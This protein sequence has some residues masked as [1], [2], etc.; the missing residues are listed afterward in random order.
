MPEQ[1]S[2]KDI[3]R[4]SAGVTGYRIVRLSIELFLVER[5]S[6]LQ[7]AVSQAGLLYLLYSLAN[8]LTGVALFHFPNAI[9]AGAATKNGAFIVPVLSAGSMTG[10]LFGMF[11]AESFSTMII[12]SLFCGFGTAAWFIYYQTLTNLAFPKSQ[13]GTVAQMRQGYECLGFLLISISLAMLDSLSMSEASSSPASDVNSMKMSIVQQSAVVLGVLAAI[14]HLVSFPVMSSYASILVASGSAAEDEDLKD[15][16]EKQTPIRESIWGALQQFFGTSVRQYF[17]LRSIL[18]AFSAILLG[19]SSLTTEVIFGLQPNF[20]W[21]TAIGFPL[22]GIISVGS[23]ILFG[24]WVQRDPNSTVR[25]GTTGLLVTLVLVIIIHPLVSVELSVPSAK[26]FLFIFGLTVGIIYSGTY[27]AAVELWYLRLKDCDVSFVSRASALHELGCQAVIAGVFQLQTI[28]IEETVSKGD[29]SRL[30]EGLVFFGPMAA[31]LLIAYLVAISLPFPKDPI[32]GWPIKDPFGGRCNR[33]T[34]AALDKLGICPIA[35]SSFACFSDYRTSMFA[36]GHLSSPTTQVQRG[37]PVD[38]SATLS[39]ECLQRQLQKYDAEYSTTSQDTWHRSKANVANFT[40]G[41]KANLEE[42]LRLIGSAHSEIWITTWTFEDSKS[43]NLLSDA[44]IA[45]AQAGVDVRVIVD[46]CNLFYLYHKEKLTRATQETKVLHKLVNGGVQVKMLDTWF[47]DKQPSYVCGTHRKMMLVDGTFL[48]TGGLN[49][50]D[51]YLLTDTFHFKDV[52]VTLQ[53]SSFAE[54]TRQLYETLWSMSREVPFYACDIDITTN[55]EK[56]LS[57]ACSDDYTESL[58]ITPTETQPPESPNRRFSDSQTSD[59]QQR[60]PHDLEAPAFGSYVLTATNDQQMNSANDSTSPISL[61]SC[62]NREVALF[63]LDHKAGNPKGQDIIFS[64]LFFLIETAQES[65]ELVFGYF[66][67]LPGLEE[68][69]AGA[70]ARG[71]KVRL[72]TNSE[73]TNDMTFENQSFGHAL[74]RVLEL[75][76]EVYLP[77]KKNDGSANYCLHYKMAIIDT[78][79]VLLG[80][81]NCLGFSTFHDDEF[82]VVMF[83]GQTKSTDEGEVRA[84]GSA[85][86]DYFLESIT[87]GDL[88]RVESIPED[89]FVVLSTFEHLQPRMLLV[90]C[91]GAFKY[92]DL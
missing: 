43:G 73:E 42:R 48:L 39:P 34:M 12:P 72:I 66:Q 75:G 35:I 56:T 6:E 89:S 53:S 14:F 37:P 28:L 7:L 46:G 1:F 36:E 60:P 62:L 33:I 81:W 64:T 70:I 21:I 92:F 88:V 58:Q 74:R 30:V 55:G 90:K 27:V 57:D 3:I 82:S 8:I 9:F 91:K 51:E 45:K 2:T 85:L 52:D 20:L 67:L 50:S 41:N 32:F 15:D 19:T 49:I 47:E 69:I 11:L 31:L 25:G 54:G 65:V 22:G 77:A 44:L 10:G 38:P 18:A 61:N 4:F 86:F 26:F 76:V 71:V 13:L 78:K 23:G 63:Q 84:L 79:A 83:G 59:H 29:P 40:T 68:A 80:S 16:I 87:E 24:S 5:T 17:A